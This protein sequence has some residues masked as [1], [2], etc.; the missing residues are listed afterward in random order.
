MQGAYN[1]G[2]PGKLREFFNFGKLREN[3]GNFKFTQGIFV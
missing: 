3:W 1:S 2:D